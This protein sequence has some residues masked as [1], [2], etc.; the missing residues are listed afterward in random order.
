MRENK[1][2]AFLLWRQIC[3]IQHV[4]SPLLHGALDQQLFQSA[5]NWL[6]LCREGLLLTQEEIGRRLGVDRTAYHKLEAKERRGD[7]SLKKL[8]EVAEKMDCELIYFVRPKKRKVFSALLW[9]RVQPR[10][11]EIYR[12][13]MR[14][15]VIK[16][17]VLA[18]IAANLTTNVKFRHEMGWSRNKPNP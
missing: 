15:D 10:A 9:E 11:L 8:K 7:I 16:P 13:R 14:T 3:Q 5:D 1:Y 12:R 4:D 2:R 18:R 17:M 6:E